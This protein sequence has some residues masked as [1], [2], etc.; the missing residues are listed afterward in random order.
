MS[1]LITNAIRSTSASADAIT[2][3]GS[4]NVTF[5]ANATCSG[6]ATGFGGGKLVNYGSVIKTDSFSASVAQGAFSSNCIEL[7]Y[8]AASTSN[9][10]LIMANL[11]IGYQHS[12]SVRMR[13]DIGGSTVDSVTGDAS[14]NRTRTTTEA[15]LSSQNQMSNMSFNFIHSSPA[16]SSTT[17]GCQIGAKDNS[18]QTVYLNRSHGDLNYDYGSRCASSL[19]ILEFE[20]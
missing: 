19:I 4:G 11:T 16:T 17:Y 15:F 8:T 6:T 18:T 14:G 2:M 3:D 20:A 1:R 5:P 9:K 10:L 12:Q 7:S 13:F